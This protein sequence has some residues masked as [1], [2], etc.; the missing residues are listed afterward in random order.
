MKK[1]LFLVVLIFSLR[2]LFATDKP[3]IAVSDFTSGNIP[4]HIAILIRENITTYLIQTNKYTIVERSEISKIIK[5]H[6]LST[7]DLAS[8][9][10]A[11]KIGKLVS[12]RGVITGTVIKTGNTY[13]VIIRLV[14]TQTGRIVRTAKKEFKSLRGIA[15]ICKRI[16]YTIANV[17][18]QTGQYNLRSLISAAL[19]D[20]PRLI[21]L[22]LKQNVN[23]N[24]KDAKSFTALMYASYYGKLRAI[25]TL[26][27]SGAKTENKD[28]YG[29]TCMHH[30]TSQGRYFAVKILYQAGAD[31]NAIAKGNTNQTPLMYAAYY[32]HTRVVRFLV[33][34]GANVSLKNSIGKSAIDIAKAKKQIEI[35]RILNNAVK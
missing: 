27:S 16:A 34:N 8:K 7:S 30:A 33:N 23:V 29:Q 20:N 26:L 9:N 25:K 24:A 4:K 5:E 15:G 3:V 22:I 28:N 10:R 12:A 14:D 17:P 6:K 19:S 13:N 18:L 21:K 35:I 31:I 1:T 2:F 11:I 32:G